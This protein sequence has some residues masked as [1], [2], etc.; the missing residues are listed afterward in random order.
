MPNYA[1]YFK[2]HKDILENLQFSGEPSQ[3]KQLTTV[4][5]IVL[6]QL[7]EQNSISDISGAKIRLDPLA[8]KVFFYKIIKKKH[9]LKKLIVQRSRNK[10]T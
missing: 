7:R 8:Q 6:D 2:Y 3:K 10:K 9:I 5:E 1:R 4:H